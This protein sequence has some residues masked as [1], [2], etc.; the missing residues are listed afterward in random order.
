MRFS[1]L[2]PC[3]SRVEKSWNCMSE[4]I[5]RAGVDLEVIISIDSN[6]PRKDE[7]LK[8]YEGFQVIV[9]D[10]DNAVMAVNAAAKVSTGDVLI[11][12]S[13][14]F[15]CPKDWGKSVERAVKGRRDFVLK[16]ADGIQPYIVTLPI[17]DRRYYDRFGYIY[18]PVYSH[19]FS[20]MEL[21]HVADLLGRMVVR[22]DILFPHRHYSIIPQRHRPAKDE[23]T[24][25]AD[26]TFEPGKKIYLD[27]VRNNFGLTR[28]ALDIANEEH[29]RWLK[30]NL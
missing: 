25:R 8:V 11:V 2:H 29:K 26:A 30:Q 4:W 28:N 7:F 24:I 18:N 22:Q 13:D 14:D 21:T 5:L 15:Q 27:R 10:N 19:M 12:V 20:D 16:T 9:N 6:D 1:I 23:V 17:L 3:R